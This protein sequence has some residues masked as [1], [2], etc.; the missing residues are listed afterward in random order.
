[1]ERREKE[2][3]DY[4]EV[5]LSRKWLFIIPFLL[6]TATGAFI[7]YTSPPLYRSTTLILVEGQKVPEDYVKPTVTTSV[8]ER[9]RTITQQIMSRTKL[10]RIIEEFGLYPYRPSRVALFMK[11]LG[12]EGW[13]RPPTKDEL[14]ARMR[15]DIEVEVVGN[16]NRVDAFKLSYIGPDPET[17]MKVTNAL[18]S[19]F[20]EENLKVREEYAEG[21][22][23]FL[24]GELER[25][26]EE[27]KRQ[28]QLIREFKQ[29]HMGAL[30]EQL[31]ANLRTLD[32]LQMEL[33]STRES[34]RRAED[35]RI[36][37]QERLA[38]LQGADDGEVEVVDPLEEELYQLRR[39]LV[40]LRSMYKETYPDVQLVKA[41]IEEIEGILESRKG[42]GEIQ[43]V[44]PEREE[45]MR[46]IEDVKTELRLLQGEIEA[47]KRRERE[48]MKEIEKYEARVEETPANE[49]RLAE[50]LREYSILQQNYQSLL[51]KRLEARLSTNLEKKQKGEQFRVLDPA[52]LP[53]S[54]FKPDRRKILLMGM[55][56]GVGLGLGLVY[57]MEYLK[58]VFR[59][60][61]DFIGLVDVP[62][63][64][65]IPRF[66]KKVLKGRG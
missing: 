60:E 17:A 24:A 22:L 50:L 41:R 46:T 6:S 25:A 26:R 14:V 62:V 30:P 8:R 19:L 23:D 28:E 18:A 53:E 10:E 61:E 52:N 4:I 3:K 42:Q 16:R 54:P 9:L 12:F 48:L 44:G 57:G 34:L 1:M 64:A 13:D 5:L 7:A 47:L 40:V 63:I 27:L 29:R 58:P 43:P 36:V 65:T 15:R 39:Q 49:Q 45:R 20:I 33:Q 31:D 35:Q 59:K 66:S 37:L 55:M 32:R 21:T 56:A 38:E 2:I 51:E 11:R